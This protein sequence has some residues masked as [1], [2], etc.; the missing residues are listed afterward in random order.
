MLI[1]TSALECMAYSKLHIVG[2]LH[3]VDNFLIVSK[4]LSSC[5]NNSRTF[6]QTCDDI[7]VPMAPEKTVG[8]SFVLSFVGIE[9]DTLKM[10]ARLPEDKLAKCCLLIQDF[11]PRK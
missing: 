8:P 7:G 11:L 1:E 2:I 6:L 10:E 9:L 3:L 4:S 5:A